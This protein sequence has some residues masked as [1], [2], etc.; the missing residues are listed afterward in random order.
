MSSRSIRRFCTLLR[1]AKGLTDMSIK[2]K[3]DADKRCP[4]FLG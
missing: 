1:L 2:G 4:N 3:G